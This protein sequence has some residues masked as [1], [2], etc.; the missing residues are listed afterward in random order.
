MSNPSKDPKFNAALQKVLK[1]PPTQNK[2]LRA[3]TKA[4]A[5]KQKEPKPYPWQKR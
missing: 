2:D 3:P 1:A 5:K 4:K